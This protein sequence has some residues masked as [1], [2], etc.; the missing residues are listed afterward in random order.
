MCLNVHLLAI[1]HFSYLQHTK[2]CSVKKWSL[3]KSKGKKKIFWI[4]MNKNTLYRNMHAFAIRIFFINNFALL[5]TNSKLW[6]ISL[7][8]TLMCTSIHYPSISEAQFLYQ[9][10]QT[11]SVVIGCISEQPRVNTTPSPL[12]HREHLCWQINLEVCLRLDK[13]QISRVGHCWEF[14]LH[15]SQCIQLTALSRTCRTENKM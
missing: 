11:V 6:L 15:S 8:W 3:F 1:E 14:T 4:E 12:T 10:V 9:R 2:M 5:Q 13:V 7:N